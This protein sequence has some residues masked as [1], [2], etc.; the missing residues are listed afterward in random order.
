MSSYLARA[1]AAITGRRTAAATRRTASKSP[2]DAT[3]NPASI[4]STPSRSSCTAMRTLS[5]GV[6]LNPGACSP[7]RSVVSKILIGKAL[8]MTGSQCRAGLIYKSN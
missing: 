7:S 2:T 4:T 8:V 6:M 5:A 3:G 1:S